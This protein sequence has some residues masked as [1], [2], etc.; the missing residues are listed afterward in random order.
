ML[1]VSTHSP[2]QSVHPP[3]HEQLP[4]TQEAL[5]GQ[6]FAQFPQCAGS[7]NT[8][9]HLPSHSSVPE[10]QAQLP[11]THCAFEGHFAPQA[12]Q[13]EGLVARS[14]HSPPQLVSADGQAATQL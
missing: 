12:P 11:C 14:T 6:A 3:S 9:T 4:C 7:A 13:W 10:E 1:E 8:S 5:S 2:P